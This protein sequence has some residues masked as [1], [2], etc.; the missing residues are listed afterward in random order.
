VRFLE[1]KGRLRQ[2]EESVRRFEQASG[3]APAV[4]LEQ[5]VVETPLSLPSEQGTESIFSPRLRR[6]TIALWLVWAGINL[7]YYGA[8]TWIPTLLYQRGMPMVR[9]FGFTLIMTLAQIPGYLAAAWLV[10]RWGRRA[11]LASF[12]AASAVAAGIYGIQT[13]PA[14]I[15]AAGCTLS[16]FNLGAWGALYAIGPEIYPTTIRGTGTGAASAIG[17]LAAIAAPLLVPILVV[18]GG[19]PLTFAVFGVAFALAAG[20]ALFLPERRARQMVE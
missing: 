1:S 17:R 11:T 10:E 15:I 16:F 3:V 12:L 14:G 20:A 8:F 9:S 4:A 13:S 5:A 6:R 18:A 7:S 19:E 2:A